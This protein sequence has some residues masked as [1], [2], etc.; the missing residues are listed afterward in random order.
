MDKIE[1]LL[2]G[3]E[4][5][6]TEILAQENLSDAAESR[7]KYYV[8]RLEILKLPPTIPP[9]PRQ[10]N[11]QEPN[12]GL[13]SLSSGDVES[14]INCKDQVP[15][16]PPRDN[17]Y[18]GDKKWNSIPVPM[19]KLDR[20]ESEPNVADLQTEEVPPETKRDSIEVEEDSDEDGTKLYDDIDPSHV[21]ETSDNEDS[22]LYEIPV[23]QT[24][25][26]SNHAVEPV[27]EVIECGNHDDASSEEAAVSPSTN[28]PPLPPRKAITSEPIRL[29]SGRKNGNR[30]LWSLPPQLPARPQLATRREI[31]AMMSEKSEHTDDNSGPEYLHR[32]W[33]MSVTQ[34]SAYQREMT[35][36][37]TKIR[38]AD[39]ERAST[40]S[41]DYDR[42]S[43]VR[44]KL[45]IRLPKNLKKIK[46]IKH[47]RKTHSSSQL[48][49]VQPVKSLEDIVISGELYLKKKLTWSKRFVVISAGRLM[50]Y[51]SEQDLRPCV[52]V[53]LAGYSVNFIDRDSRHGYELKLVHPTSDTLHFSVDYRD[54]A[55]IWTE[56]MRCV[57]EGRPVP[58]SP[59]FLN[60]PFSGHS[61]SGMGSRD[62]CRIQ[63]YPFLQV[64]NN[65]MRGSVSNLSN[66]SSER[67]SQDENLHRPPSTS[68]YLSE[69]APPRMGN[70][71]L[72][73]SRF[74][75][76]LN[77]RRYPKKDPDLKLSRFSLNSLPR[78]KN[79]TPDTSPDIPK[80]EKLVSLL[81]QSWQEDTNILCKSYLNIYSSFNKRRWGKRWCLVKM[82]EF[83]CYMNQKNNV[84]EL[85]FPLKDCV[86]RSAKTE[87]KSDL[88]LMI[89]KDN[90]EKITVEPL[91][92]DEMQDWL[93]VLMAET[94][95]EN[96]P[97]GLEQYF[98][99]TP[100]SDIP[101][102]RQSS[103]KCPKNAK[104]TPDVIDGSGQTGKD[105]ENVV[106]DVASTL[107]DQVVKVSDGSL[108]NLK[109]E[110]LLRV[111]QETFGAT[112]VNEEIEE[113]GNEVLLWDVNKRNSLG[114]LY[115]QVEY[116]DS[117]AG[118]S[119]SGTD[120]GSVS[121][122]DDLSMK[123][124]SIDFSL[125]RSFSEK[126][127]KGI[128]SLANSCSELN[129]T[130][131]RTSSHGNLDKL[132]AADSNDTFND[133]FYSWNNQRRSSELLSELDI[134]TLMRSWDVK[135]KI[136]MIEE[137][138]QQNKEY[139]KTDFAQNGNTCHS[140]SNKKPFSVGPISSVSNNDCDTPAF[141]SRT[142]SLN[143]ARMARNKTTPNGLSK[144]AA[145]FRKSTGHVD[146]PADILQTKLDEMRSKLV[147]LKQNR[148]ATRD[149][150]LRASDS[151][152]RLEYEEEYNR[153][154]TECRV[155]DEEIS[156]LEKM[157][158][159]EEAD[160]EDEAS[161]FS[162]SE[163]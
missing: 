76:N 6:F 16:L 153:L 63:D 51:K 122:S 100:Y 129:S 128:N 111:K 115:S 32:K 160:E 14:F 147:S 30:L 150:K 91:N 137:K 17:Q 151:N 162:V 142:K 163:A 66:D 38:K 69:K 72:R 44:S 37:L 47:S 31:Y 39:E 29:E 54:W 114:N 92:D 98:E 48:E 89:L 78:K 145:P 156:K 64:D 99:E 8:E 149:K 28:R 134:E 155:T 35:D 25:E 117:L 4:S 94:S 70:L 22:D 24:S 34:L 77:W 41:N 73:A 138:N 19:I 50:C 135:A 143:S 42:S 59:H 18:T 23:T 86:V 130:C 13:F 108:T 141:C 33:I 27:V 105:G 71:A 157:L 62:S 90:I 103:M 85:S 136:L 12:K 113:S 40:C 49:L 109:D 161:R 95:T 124:G 120:F 159:S 119:G 61:D 60:R 144:A 36:V 9:R 15:P 140:P 152:E 5:F 65:D 46:K 26:E 93:A 58:N 83:E 1:E 127:Y 68:E 133:F 97:E 43:E 10:E 21:G 74:F 123:S 101:V 80:S 20:A 52:V 112:E 131:T 88:G 55:L 132:S 53:N 7:C 125:K 148:I 75:E 84:C 139:S 57:S 106:D 11:P 116:K 79:S 56:G 82:G 45:S 104:K 121:I 67:G 154:D 110:Q 118:F 146:R 96:V 158:K 87:T 3:I 107:S 2:P 102:V 126:R 81:E